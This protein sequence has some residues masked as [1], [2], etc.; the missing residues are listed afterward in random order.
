M[1]QR[2]GEVLTSDKVRMLQVAL[3]NDAL[4]HTGQYRN[5][6]EL[7]EDEITLLFKHEQNRLSTK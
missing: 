7:G 5:R 4:L 2:Q 6:I 3:R 1:R